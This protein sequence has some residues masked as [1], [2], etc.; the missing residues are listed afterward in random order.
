MLQGK[1]IEHGEA[2]VFFIP[3]KQASKATIAKLS[4]YD[5]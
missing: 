3:R 2:A 5:C 4:V 1:C